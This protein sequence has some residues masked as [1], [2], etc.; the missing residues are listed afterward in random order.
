DLPAFLRA[1]DDHARRRVVIE[2]TE[3]HPLVGTAHLWRH[4]WGIERPD[5]PGADD[6]VA[7]ILECG[8]RPQL[9]RWTRA[10]RHR[11][12]PREALVAFTRRRLCLTPDRDPEID[13]LLPAE[14][15]PRQVVTIWWDVTRDSGS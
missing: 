13:E 8:I 9:E 4:F 3:R 6:L 11:K 12:V 5:G 10:D 2:I 14:P 1:L 15:P 7:V